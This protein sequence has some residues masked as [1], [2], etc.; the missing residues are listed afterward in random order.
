MRDFVTLTGSTRVSCPGAV[1]FK[2]QVRLVYL[3]LIAHGSSE[4]S[5]FALSV[6]AGIGCLV[7]LTL[8]D[9]TSP[10][11]ECLLEKERLDLGW[12]EVDDDGPFTEE[13]SSVRT[14]G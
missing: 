13:I 4:R 2:A 14:K 5:G 3:A 9:P 8:G 1:G 7:W 6:C 11:E 10:T 12:L